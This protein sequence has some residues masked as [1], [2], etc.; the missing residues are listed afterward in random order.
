MVDQNVKNGSV[1]PDDED[2]VIVPTGFTDTVITKEHFARKGENVVTCNMLVE[3]LQKKIGEE[4]VCPEC[5]RKFMVIKQ[6]DM[7]NFKK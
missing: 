1:M 7:V 5:G 2:V 3:D 4:V 6:E